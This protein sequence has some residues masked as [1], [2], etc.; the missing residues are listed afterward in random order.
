MGLYDR[1]YTQDGYRDHYTAF[2]KSS[3]PALN[4][5]SPMEAAADP[6]MRSV[7]L[8]M[9]KDHI[10]TIEKENL[11]WSTH[12]SIDWVLKELGLEELLG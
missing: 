2:L 3:I 6:E 7:L 5:M 9:M 4:G 8:T 1:D 11:T 12:I 10:R